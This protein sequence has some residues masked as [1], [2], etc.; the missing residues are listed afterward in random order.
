M[1]RR[2]GLPSRTLGRAA[3]ARALFSLS[4][5]ALL[6]AGTLV[7]PAAAQEAGA[8]SFGH[9]GGGTTNDATTTD[10]T[11]PTFVDSTNFY[12]SLTATTTGTPGDVLKSEAATYA[13]GAN[14]AGW[15]DS[16]AQRIAYVSTDSRGQLIPVTGAVL[17]SA[18]PWVGPGKRPLLAIAPGTVGAGDHCAPSRS[19]NSDF[20]SETPIIVAA[21]NRGWN[22]ALT[23]LPGLGNPAIQHTYMNRVDQ[24]NATLDVAKAAAKLG[25]AGLD[26][27]NP[28]ATWGYSQGGGASAAAV[29]LQPTYAPDLNLVAGMA[30]GTPADLTMTADAVAGTALG[31]AIGYTI[32]GL[33]H[34]YP[35]IRPN[36][37]AAM[38]EKGRQLLEDTKDHCMMDRE[39]GAEG[40]GA[41]ATGEQGGGAEGEQAEY[42]DSRSLTKSGKPLGEI[43]RNDPQIR[44]VIEKQRIGNLKPEVPV[45]VAHGTNDDAIP[46]AQA[47]TMVK[48][49]C[50]AGAKVQYME[51]PIPTVGPMIDHAIPLFGSLAP[52]MQW[53]DFGFLTGEYPLATCG[54]IPGS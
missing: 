24:G 42:V 54:N 52:A 35:E 32:N 31:S 4:A 1:K 12:G 11:P 18:I 44:A 51:L 13:P 27:S 3:S 38:N 28:V 41:G 45:F 6:A 48:Q 30:G 8:Y 10:A 50:E 46:V 43:M 49:W 26:A 29:E 47:R 2:H 7:S 19:L 20:T 22:V 16:L 53:L 37:E 14:V 15:K 9:P 5:T 23:D 34:S 33:L 39:E 21:L 36:V 25:I 17:A 40:D